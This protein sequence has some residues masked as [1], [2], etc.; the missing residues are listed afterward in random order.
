MGAFLNPGPGVLRA[1]DVTGVTLLLYGKKLEESSR[2]KEILAFWSAISG[3]APP[4]FAAFRR[5]GDADELD[6]LSRY[7][8]NIEVSASL[9]SSLHILEV[10]FRNQLSLSLTSLH[11]VNWYEKPGL[12]TR[13]E[14][15][16]VLDAKGSLTRKNRDHDPGRIIA[17]LPFGFWSSLYGRHHEIDIVRPTINSVFRYY[18]DSRPLT[19]ASVAGVIRDAR[20]L[21]NRI[22]HHEQVVLNPS[23]A[24]VHTRITKLISWMSPEMAIFAATCDHFAS[25]YGATWKKYRPTLD[26]LF[27]RNDQGN[28]SRRS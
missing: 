28:S 12:L 23:L 10:T 18:S 11:G 22:S 21:R 3:L 19:R 1:E 24:D 8:W 27:P 2:S 26:A 4:R 17:E 5:P 9:Q 6:A 16:N 25:V 15:Q 13:S 7:I 20:L 14:V